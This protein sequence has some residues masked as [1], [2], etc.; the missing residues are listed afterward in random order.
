[1]NSPVMDRPYPIEREREGEPTE[2]GRADS[3]E[4]FTLH[5]APSLRHQVFHFLHELPFSGA[6]LAESGRLDARFFP[7]SVLS[8]LANHSP[9]EIKDVL[10][11]LI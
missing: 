11:P 4:I 6:L 5:N 7:F 8:T 1:M 2:N 3:L 9:G 10:R